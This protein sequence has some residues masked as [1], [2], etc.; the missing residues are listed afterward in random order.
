MNNWLRNIVSLIIVIA[1]IVV[2]NL[3]LQNAVENEVDKDTAD[4]SQIEYISNY[5][6]SSVTKIKIDNEYGTV[7]LIYKDE[8]WFLEDKQDIELD[9]TV[10]SELAYMLTHMVGERIVSDAEDTTNTYGMLEPT[11]TITTYHEGILE[12]KFIIGNKAPLD[13]QYYLQSSIFNKVYTVDMAYYIY[14]QI[15][16]EDLILLKGLN[17]EHGDMRQIKVSNTLGEQF[18]IQRIAPENDVSL[19]Y[20]E[21][22][23][24]FNHDIDTAVMYG[25]ENYK[26]MI[27]SITELI[28]DRVV[29]DIET[30]R[31]TYGLD[32]PIYV[33]EIT[34]SSEK[35]KSFSIGD[36]GD[37]KS[38]SLK[39][40]DD[41]NIYKISK[42]RVPFINYSIYMIA[43][44]NLNLISIDAV[45]K[46]TI[47]LMDI[48]TEI[49]VVFDD[50]ELNLKINTLDESS[51]STS[52]IEQQKILFYQDIVSV[53]IDDVILDDVI[54]KN[55]IGNITFDLNSQYK[56]QYNIE[57]YEY[58]LSHY[59]AKKNNDNACY[60]INKNQINKLQNSYALLLEGK[61][62]I[63]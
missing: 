35:A 59:I 1:I 6:V 56:S 41:D 22:T 49:N 50:N 8:V 44:A 38:Y 26:G 34:S 48:E 60:L 5:S 46:V 36:Y 23:K 21:F 45:N 25:S 13:N 16:V 39:F 55:E 43:D 2:A 17:I 9:Q 28:G 37:E 61:L 15:Q 12:Q 33:A 53:K 58:S 20:W 14:G 11:A 18:T 42:N 47:D 32:N 51:I 4:N 63:D 19:C 30:N 57:F 62:T 3:L 40:S 29:G 54:I 7:E 27:T 24:P 52:D 31:K 10:V